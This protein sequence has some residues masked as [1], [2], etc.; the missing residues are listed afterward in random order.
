MAMAIRF[1]DRSYGTAD[2]AA[3][4]LVGWAWPAIVLS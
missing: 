1:L 2:E 3:I 4:R